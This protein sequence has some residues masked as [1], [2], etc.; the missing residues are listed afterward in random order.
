MGLFH[1]SFAVWLMGFV[2]KEKPLMALLHLGTCCFLSSESMLASS[3]PFLKLGARTCSS[4]LCW[5][6]E[7]EFQ[8]PFTL[9]NSSDTVMSACLG[10][11][12]SQGMRW[13][14]MVCICSAALALPCT[15]IRYFRT[16]SLCLVG[17]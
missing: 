4:L 7:H 16:L 11:L 17:A 9:Q 14:F 15:S 3:G 13:C 10:V 5:Q 8:L 2:S 12:S 6:L 1:T